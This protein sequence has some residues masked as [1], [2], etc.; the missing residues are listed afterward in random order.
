MYTPPTPSSKW[1][2]VL[3]KVQWATTGA[4]GLIGVYYGTQQE[5]LPQWYGVSCACLAFVWTYTGTAAD[6]NVV[7]DTP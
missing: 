1:R 4:T 6:Q 2:K 3:Y 5:A 7:D